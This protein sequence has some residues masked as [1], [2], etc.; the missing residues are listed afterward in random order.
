MSRV[1]KRI[2]PVTV[3][4]VLAALSVVGGISLAAGTYQDT[5]TIC[6]VDLVATDTGREYRIY[7]PE[8]G[9]FRVSSDFASQ[10]KVGEVW[11][12][13][14]KQPQ[15]GSLNREIVEATPAPGESPAICTTP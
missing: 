3:A 13:H 1:F 9:K 6:A 2:I 4:L 10:A 15:A 12:L 5:V 14:Y 7:T 8:A 11:T